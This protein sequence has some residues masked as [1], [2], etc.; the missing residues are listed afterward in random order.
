MSRTVTKFKR[1]VWG[2]IKIVLYFVAA[3]MYKLNEKIRLIF[4][5]FL[6]I[7][8]AFVIGY[9]FLNWLLVIKTGFISIKEDIANFWLPYLLPWIPLL[10]WLRPRVKLLHFKKDRNYFGLIF[11]PA[12]AIG[13]SSM[14]LQSYITTATGK[15]ATLKDIKE[16]NDQPSTKYY[17]IKSFYI[18]RGNY[19]LKYIS[20][21]SGKS[22]QYLN[23]HIY[24][25][26]P[27]YSKELEREM[28]P[29]KIDPVEIDQAKQ[30][31]HLFILDGMPV[32]SIKAYTF[33][34]D[35]IDSVTVLKGQSAIALYGDRAKNGVMIIKSKRPTPERIL[36]PEPDAWCCINY[37]KQISNNLS[38]EEKR[39]AQ[40]TFYD[41]CIDRYNKEDLN[42][43]IYLNR[44]GNNDARAG[45]LKAIAKSGARVNQKQLNILE[46]VTE[47][48][49]ERNGNN[50]PLGLG[51]FV[52]M[53]MIFFLVLLLLKF[54]ET[55]LEQFQNG[56]ITEHSDVKEYLSYFIPKPGYYITPIL[57]D[58]NILIFGL[59]VFAGYG[60]ISV[61]GQALLKWGGNYGPMTNHGQWWR[62]LT[63]TF[64][65]AGV[66][67]VFANMIG[68]L[69]A[70]IFLEPLLGRRAFL[71]A[72][73]G[74]G[75]AGSI[76][77][78]WWQNATLSV[79][80]S[81]AVFGL[82]GVFLALLLFKT[83]PQ[84][85]NR[86]FL[87]SILIFIVY[88]LLMG[89]KGGIDNAAHIGGL[90]SGFIVGLLLA[91]SVKRRG[92]KQ[93]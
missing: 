3:A 77:S 10:I 75:V 16:I 55:R 30:T 25:A 32:D 62:L 83:F 40:E 67:H 11:L 53:S 61:D 90:T 44:I 33:P 65:H 79:G 50:L 47:P 35:S 9:S 5:P 27:M 21:V 23:L 18:A 87:I 20:D 88:N 59:M 81:G 14:F 45:Y 26:C 1:K 85:L 80:A 73:L 13:I 76:A 86:T 24:F 63:S 15:L 84:R 71:L 69:F 46:P 19:G 4:L 31:G 29:I 36:L 37:K 56:R 17:K 28:E 6:I 41:N 48:F 38:H 74:T 64:L 68:L 93:I 54:D 57:I 70:G 12:I 78:I 34:K 42:L 2:N 22:S 39:K 72:Y 52:V 7:A 49:S 92:G 60:F 89:I 51:V 82:Y 91:G 66:M 58:L 8:V 43:F